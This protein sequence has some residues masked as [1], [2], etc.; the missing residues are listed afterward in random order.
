MTS[1]NLERLQLHSSHAISQTLLAF[2][3][4][5]DCFMILP[6]LFCES[7]PQCHSN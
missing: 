6:V 3:G 4:V 7:A 1:V 5:D 2:V